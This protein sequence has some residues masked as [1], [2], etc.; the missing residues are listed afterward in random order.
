MGIK[1]FR[2]HSQLITF[3]GMKFISYLISLYR[4]VNILGVPYKRGS[5]VHLDKT[6]FSSRGSAVL[7]AVTKVFLNSYTHSHVD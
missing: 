4:G 1:L 6:N 7:A 3:L 5:T 2:V